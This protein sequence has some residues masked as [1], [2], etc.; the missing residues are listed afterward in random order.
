MLTDFIHVQPT[1][2]INMM[3]D[4]VMVSSL[5]LVGFILGFTSLW[6]VHRR[7]LASLDARLAHGMVAL[8]LLLS[9]FAIYL[10]RELR[11]SSWDVVTNPSG[12][13]LNISDRVVDPLGNQHSLN[14]TGLFFVLLGTTYLA[15]CI[16]RPPK[17]VR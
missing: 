13:V 2:Q 6:L 4:I 1:G 14:I 8:V 10:G 12:L 3:Y 5:V 15:I 16:F 9:S 7:L 17:A 11:W